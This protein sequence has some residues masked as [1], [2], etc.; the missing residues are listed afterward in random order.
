MLFTDFSHQLAGLRS[1]L[2]ARKRLPNLIVAAINRNVGA[3]IGQGIMAKL[4]RRHI[5]RLRDEGRKFGIELLRNVSACRQLSGQC[6]GQSPLNFGVVMQ[7]PMI[8]LA[9]LAKIAVVGE[10]VPHPD[11]VNVRNPRSKD[12]KRTHQGAHSL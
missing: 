4:G 10:P 12:R 2:H 11:A 3:L 5:T 1:R 7:L 9:P 8:D 6:L